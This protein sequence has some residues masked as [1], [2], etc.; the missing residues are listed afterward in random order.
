VLFEK[1]IEQHRVHRCI[2]NLA[3]Q[4][5]LRLLASNAE[6][7]SRRDFMLYA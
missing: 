1:F 4:K 6:P 7:P 3:A 5:T 2:S